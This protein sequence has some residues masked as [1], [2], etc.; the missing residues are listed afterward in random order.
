ME[1][2]TNN[3]IYSRDDRTTWWSWC[4]LMYFR[5]MVKVWPIRYCYIYESVERGLMLLF[6]SMWYLPG[7]WVLLRYI[8]FKAIDHH[9]SSLVSCPNDDIFIVTRCFQ[10]FFLSLWQLM[11]SSIS[12]PPQSVTWP[13]CHKP[14]YI[15]GIFYATKTAVCLFGTCYL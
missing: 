12:R 9:S 4:I 3:T 13:A 7:C 11:D 6:H 8:C 5:K 1:Q 15:N 14:W 2:V 10:G